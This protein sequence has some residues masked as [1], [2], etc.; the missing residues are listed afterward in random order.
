MVDIVP[1]SQK[2]EAEITHFKVSEEESKWTAIRGR[3]DEIVAA[4]DYVRLSVCG[5]LVMSDTDHEWASNRS[6]MRH[7][8]GDILIAGLG[9]GMILTSILENQRVNSVLVI[10]KYQEVIDLVLPHLLSKIDGSSKLTVVCSNIF[11]WPLPKERGWDCIYFDIW[12]TYCIDNLQQM[13]KLKRR[14]ARRLKRDNP[15]AFM[16]CW[17]EAELRRRKKASAW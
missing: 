2:G 4:G 12:P 14:F 8:N 11:D 17:K 1:I 10:E 3:P 15:S 6:A 5:E 16:G 9:I 13:T 7:A